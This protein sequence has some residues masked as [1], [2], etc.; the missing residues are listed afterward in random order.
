MSASAQSGVPRRNE[1]G[2]GRLA[3]AVIPSKW[4]VDGWLGLYSLLGTCGVLFILF[5]TLTVQTV[6]PLSLPR[7]VSL[8]LCMQDESFHLYAIQSGICLCF[9]SVWMCVYL[10][11]YHSSL[12][13][14]VL[15]G[16]G[17]GGG[18]RGTSHGGRSF[19]FTC[20]GDSWSFPQ[21]ALRFSPESLANESLS[22]PGSVCVCI[23]YL[24]SHDP[25]RIWG[26]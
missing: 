2:P 22:Q 15:E 21:K 16:G 17:G 3:N 7:Q 9:S 6:R 26:K 19:I 8:H 20:H 5:F 14:L 11:M 4:A 10:R 25:R 12:K 24:Q 23:D 1:A 13:W 18:G